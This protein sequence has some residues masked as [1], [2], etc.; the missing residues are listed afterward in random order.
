MLAFE[1]FG[2]TDVP[3]F[4]LPLTRLNRSRFAFEYFLVMP[5]DKLG[6]RTPRAILRL[7]YPFTV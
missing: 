4:H 5:S 3:D 1:I 7:P 6:R 2:F